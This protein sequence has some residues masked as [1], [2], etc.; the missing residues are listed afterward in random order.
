MSGGRSGRE[1]QPPHAPPK[2]KTQLFS[3]IQLHRKLFSE[4]SRVL[5]HLQ[6]M[7]MIDPPRQRLPHPH[8][9]IHTEGGK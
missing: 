6:E 3:L 2:K 7:H 5:L 1:G 9:W 4:I 8:H